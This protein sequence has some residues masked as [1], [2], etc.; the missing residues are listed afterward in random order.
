MLTAVDTRFSV[1]DFPT[2]S[3]RKVLF[4]IR[5]LK[6]IFAWLTLW[7]DSS[8]NGSIF[9][10]YEYTG[11]FESIR[12]IEIFLFAL[13]GLFLI[14]R[15]LTRD[16][17]FARSY[18]STP[19]LLILLGL[20][21]SWARG[22]YFTQ[23]YT[24]VYEVHEAFE[25][26]FAFLLILNLFREKEDRLTLIL[27]LILATVPKSVEG[28]Y[29]KF[30]SDD[31]A[32]GWGVLMMWRDGFLLALGVVGL[33]LT[34]HYKG[35]KLKW[36]RKVMLI[37]SPFL[38]FTLIVSYRRSFLLAVLVSAFL[39]LITVGKGKRKKHAWMLVGLL[40]SLIIFVLVTDPIG[41]LGRISG[42][43]EPKE[44]GSA[45]IRLMELPNVLLNIYHNPIFGTPIGTEWHQYYR[46]PLFAN[47]TTLGVHNTYLY[48]SLRTGLLG[49]IGFFWLMGRMWKS[50]LI[51]YRLAKTE[52]D[53]FISQVS[54][55]MIVIYQVASFF[56]MM[57]GDA[58]T[59]LLAVV[60]TAF[61]LQMKGITGRTS[62]RYVRLWET[63]RT[64]ELVYK[65]PAQPLRL[66]SSR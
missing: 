55:H 41:F 2:E 53:W 23:N 49:A 38:F 15:T 46:M 52:E 36:L 50:A 22:V 4:S 39:L 34:M 11:R 37:S 29:I 61:Q 10:L 33:M 7:Q 44:E 13:V 32:K 40:V 63:L 57:Y 51:N 21:T 24:I 45:Y 65:T 66:P 19:L 62:Y 47:F 26:P 42:I 58:V 6:Y 3:D 28:A 25:L 1:K 9:Q 30:F 56:G 5:Y 14:E 31:P 64:G 8:I 18:F 35:E 20:F 54:I 59:I 27:L 60:L 48:W 43:I 16:Y 12:P 17:T